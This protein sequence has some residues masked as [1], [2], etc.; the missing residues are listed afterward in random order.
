MA[1]PFLLAASA[2]RH[3][4]TCL[5]RVRKVGLLAAAAG[6]R[7]ALGLVHSV[8]L[9][10][11]PCWM[12]VRRPVGC[13]S[14]TG[15][16]ADQIEMKRNQSILLAFVFGGALA[17]SAA[18]AGKADDKQQSVSL[19]YLQAGGTRKFSI[20]YVGQVQN[21]PT[22]TRKLR[23]WMPAPQS[24][25]VQT[26]K[27]LQFAPKAFL[28]IEPKYLNLIAYWEFVN[29]PSSIR[30]KMSFTCT[31]RETRA[32]LQSLAADGQEA[33]GKFDVYKKPDRLVIV[34]E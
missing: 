34:D 22:G 11:G 17:A 14:S 27:Q 13:D 19:H 21:I 12:G 24:S 8:S 31:R 3:L 10:T 4:A 26:I 2:G 16:L 33:A 20:E 6:R 28:T 23:V 30:L 25:T 15:S 7:L 29:P 9:R 18:Q 32:D 5:E 1:W